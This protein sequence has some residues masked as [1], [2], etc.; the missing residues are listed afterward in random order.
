MRRGESRIAGWEEY[1]L[2]VDDQGQVEK[3]DLFIIEGRK[4]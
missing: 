2:E 4:A 3:P 1:H